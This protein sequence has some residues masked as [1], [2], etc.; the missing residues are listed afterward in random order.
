MLRRPPGPPLTD[1]LV[2]YPTLFRSEIAE[3][4]AAHRDH[5][6][7]RGDPRAAAVLARAVGRVAHQEQ[8]LAMPELA[9]SRGAQRVLGALGIGGGAVGVDDEDR[10]STRLN[11]SH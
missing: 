4:V 3:L 10:K 2:P 1:T 9:E 8:G 11:S 7:A 5:A 6:P